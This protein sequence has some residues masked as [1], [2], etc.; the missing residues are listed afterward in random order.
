MNKNIILIVFIL[1]MTSTPSLGQKQ[2]LKTIIETMDGRFAFYNGKE[3]MIQLLKISGNEIKEL[4]KFK[5]VSE[6]T[7]VDPILVTDKNTIWQFKNLG[8]SIDIVSLSQDD[9]L[10]RQKLVVDKSVGIRRAD[11]VSDAQRHYVILLLTDTLDSNRFKGAKLIRYENGAFL[12]E[13]IDVLRGC[14]F[15]E[16][17]HWGTMDRMTKTFS[18]SSGIIIVWTESPVPNHDQWDFRLSQKNTSWTQPIHIGT[19]GWDFKQ[20]VKELDQNLIIGWLA[21]NQKDSKCESTAICCAEIKGN[22]GVVNQNCFCDFPEIFSFHIDRF[23]LFEATGNLVLFFVVLDPELGELL[24]SYDVKSKQYGSFTPLSE[25]YSAIKYYPY[26]SRNEV[27][28]ILIVA[29]DKIEIHE[30]SNNEMKKSISAIQ[31]LDDLY[32]LENSDRIVEFDP[33]K[34]QLILL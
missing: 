25:T 11:I 29:K 12:L 13:D 31:D 21:L 30:Y 28:N 24:V 26:L 8:N 17:A 22:M 23:K 33:N 32:F 4:A 34:G 9:T 10:I 3:N 15:C 7:P 5:N 1:G 2:I 18:A 6:F 14:H 16:N 20:E 19:N 27:T